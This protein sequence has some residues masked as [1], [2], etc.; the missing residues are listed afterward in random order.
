M[1]SEQ[2]EKLIELALADGELTEKEKQILFKRAEAEGIDLD[3]FE[4]VLDAKVFEKTKSKTNETTAAPQSNKFGDIKKCPA[5]G[6]IVESFST[7]CGDCGHNFIGGISNTSINKLFEMLNEIEGK[8]KDSTLGSLATTFLS[9]G[10]G[11]GGDKIDSQKIEIIKNFPIP[12]TKEDILEFL[13]LAIPNAKKTGS[14]WQ[15]M[16]KD[17]EI[18]L[19]NKFVP[20]WKAKCEQIIMKAR[21]SMKEDKKTLNEIEYYS[22]ELDINKS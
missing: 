8:R 19:H 21:F 14:F 6:A 11:L 22:K 5:C 2:L 13:S 3:E 15:K 9:K 1:Y 4:I 12:T 10:F 17:P 20:V 7:R 16:N 18:E